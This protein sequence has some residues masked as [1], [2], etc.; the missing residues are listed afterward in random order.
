M[1]NGF[2]YPIISQ[3]Q[4]TNGIKGNFLYFVPS[5]SVCKSV[6]ILWR[7]TWNTKKDN[8]IGMSVV[9]RKPKLKAFYEILEIKL[10]EIMPLWTKRSFGH[11][12][13]KVRKTI[14]S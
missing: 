6:D 2:L 5:N 10:P 1:K 7:N 9:T 8:F 12:A 11:M 3:T 4:E 14:S 13:I